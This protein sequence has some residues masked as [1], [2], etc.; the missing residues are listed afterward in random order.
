MEVD[1]Y[2]SEYFSVAKFRAAYAENVPAFL[3]K[4]QWNI[5]DPGFKLRSPVLTRPPGRP[6]KTG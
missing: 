6:R 5:V 3:G 2:C 4:D 1:Q